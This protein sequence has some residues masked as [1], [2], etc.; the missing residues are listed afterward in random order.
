MYSVSWLNHLVLGLPV[1]VFPFHFY[2]NFHAY[3][4]FRIVFSLSSQL[5]NLLSNFELLE[6]CSDS[7]CVPLL[8]KISCIGNSFDIKWCLL[9]ELT[10]FTSL[11]C[12]QREQF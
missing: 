11:Q 5:V 4:N 6:D 10:Q 1:G 8:H 9:R 2:S 7:F 3:S 12:L